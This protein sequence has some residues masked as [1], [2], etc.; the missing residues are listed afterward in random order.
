MESSD[1]S[2][3][4]GWLVRLGGPG[5]KG[6]VDRD[7]AVAEMRATGADKLFP[8]LVPMLT[9]PDVEVRCKGCEA[10]LWL[11][12]QRG[13]ELV[14]PLLRDPDVA[15]RL[16]ACEGLWELGDD[17]AV[18]SLV[19]SLRTDEDPQVRGMAARALGSV[20]GPEVIPTFLAVMDSDHQLDIHRHSPN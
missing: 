15:V 16:T 19:A 8:L 9:D 17:R 18:A 7:R 5:F 4:E 12:A 2:R 20:G 6:F 3:L 1:Q 14:L 11:D 10:V 13:V